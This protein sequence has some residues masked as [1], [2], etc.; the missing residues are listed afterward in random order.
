M[1][2]LYYL[3]RN[4]QLGTIKTNSLDVPVRIPEDLVF[5]NLRKGINF[6]KEPHKCIDFTDTERLIMSSEFSDMSLLKEYD[7]RRE[8]TYLTALCTIDPPLDDIVFPDESQ[9]QYFFDEGSVLKFP[10]HAD[11]PDELTN[12]YVSLDNITFLRIGIELD[13]NG[14]HWGDHQRFYF[15]DLNAT[16]PEYNAEAQNNPFYCYF[17]NVVTSHRTKVF[18][19]TNHI[20]LGVITGQVGGNSP[21]FTFNTLFGSQYNPMNMIITR[22]AGGIDNYDQNS[23][24][25]SPVIGLGLLTGDTIQFTSPNNQWLASNIYTVL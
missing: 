5:C 2:V 13:S 1:Y 8:N 17:E 21:T 23:T 25:Q 3:N 4:L 12:V 7:F 15:S 19:V 18:T 16:H 6:I 14:F 22:L 10:Q 20:A 11:L 24:L 9:V